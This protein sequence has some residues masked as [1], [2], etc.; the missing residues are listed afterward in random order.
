MPADTRRARDPRNLPRRT[1]IARL[2][3]AKN[4]EGCDANQKHSGDS[5]KLKR[6]P[7]RREAPA[8][9]R[10]LFDRNLIKRRRGLIVP[11]TPQQILQFL[12]FRVRL[13]RAVPQIIVFHNRIF[14][15]LTHV[16][17]LVSA[18]SL[19][20]PLRGRGVKRSEEHTSELQSRVDLVCRLLLEKKKHR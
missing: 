20:R 13:A 15:V 19:V 2:P 8:A 7:K 3:R 1:G 4:N 16:R 5:S 12:H 10:R 6:E 17:S 9:R 18:P 14:F 11:V